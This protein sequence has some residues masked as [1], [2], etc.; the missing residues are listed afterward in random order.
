MATILSESILHHIQCSETH[1]S[2]S[3]HTV[4]A[5][6]VVRTISQH[7]YSAWWKVNRFL[8]NGH[9]NHVAMSVVSVF[10]HALIV[11]TSSEIIKGVQ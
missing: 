1:L 2:E 5:H 4:S 6:G 8:P 7:S 9:N 11:N 3:I 10:V